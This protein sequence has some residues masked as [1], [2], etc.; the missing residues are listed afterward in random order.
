[1]ALM[2]D[3]GVSIQDM[4]RCPF[5]GNDA[6]FSSC[7]PSIAAPNFRSQRTDAGTVYEYTHVTLAI[8]VATD[9]GLPERFGMEYLLIGISNPLLS[10]HRVHSSKVFQT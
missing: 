1:M 4:S 7:P 10:E 8:Q 9:N 6:F 5:P 2:M 3:I